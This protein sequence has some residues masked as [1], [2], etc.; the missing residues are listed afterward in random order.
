[1]PEKAKFDG[2]KVGERQSRKGNITKRAAGSRPGRRLQSGGELVS[3][4]GPQ[5]KGTY[6][7]A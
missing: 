4:G 5:K 3:F 1:M 2:K 7:L 6:D